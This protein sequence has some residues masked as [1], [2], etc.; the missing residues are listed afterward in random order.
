MPAVSRLTSI[1][2]LRGLVMIIMALDHVRDFF[3]RG[4]MSSSPTDLAVTT[5]VLFFTRWVTHICAPVFMLTAG[6]GAYLYWRAGNRTKAQLSWFLLTRGLWLIFVELTFMQLAYNFDVSSRYPVLLLVLWVLGACMI[7]LAVL[8]WLPLPVVAV[9][10]GAAIVFHH[11]W[12]GV[13]VWNLVHQVSV[14]QIAGRTV[15]APYTLVPWFAVMALGFCMGPLFEI[16][17]NR[18]RHVLIRIGLGATVAF[19]IIRA[20][21]LDGDPAPWSQALPLRTLLSFL[22]TTKYPPSLS[23]LLM[24]LGPALILL[25]WLEGKSLSR[26]NP[27]IVFGRVPLFYFVLHF[28]LAHALAVLM[29]VFTHGSA[30]WTFMFQPLPSMGGPA[31]A[32][33]EAFGNEL[34]VTYVMWFVVVA[35]M[36]PLCR[37]FARV[38]EQHRRN[39]WLSYL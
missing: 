6:M 34:W 15:I 28:F 10:S 24:T 20:I 36:Y 22:N 30:A 17:A 25:A 33:P 13:Q 12:D 29:S 9:L 38:R 14:F 21:N 11:L 35:M 27:L 26:S 18:R 5:P 31:A 16:D 23:F 2:A 39:P 3:H 1:D 37:W 7:V 19:V 8:A 4:A 32:F